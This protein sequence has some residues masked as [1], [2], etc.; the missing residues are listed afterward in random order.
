M[1]TRN[2]TTR[3]EEDNDGRRKIG[4]AKNDTNRCDIGRKATSAGALDESQADM[5]K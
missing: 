1:K 2:I 5:K 4:T 3:G